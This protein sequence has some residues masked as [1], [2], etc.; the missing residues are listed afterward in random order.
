MQKQNIFANVS[1]VYP[2]PNG[3]SLI[4]DYGNNWFIQ[5]TK[6]NS[7]RIAG[8]SKSD[9]IKLAFFYLSLLLQINSWE[10]L[11]NYDEIFFFLAVIKSFEFK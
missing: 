6:V 5:Y 2:L 1:F 7:L 8:L 9:V 3:E 10:Q 11:V 4:S